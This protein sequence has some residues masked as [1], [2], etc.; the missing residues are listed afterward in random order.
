MSFMGDVMFRLGVKIQGQPLL[1][2]NTVGAR[3]GKRRSSVLGWFPDD[4][5]KHSWIVVA[6]N[7]GSARHPGWAYNLAANPEMATVD[8]GDGEAPVDVE[9]LTGAERASVWK[10]VAETAPGYGRYQEKTDR[11]MPLFRLTS[12]S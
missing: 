6:A 1:R 5:R 4:E 8:V 3:T 2:L 11:E 12:R 10:W 7:A 9:L